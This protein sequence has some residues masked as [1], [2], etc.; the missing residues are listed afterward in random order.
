[1]YEKNKYIFLILL[2]NVSKNYLKNE[3]CF[4]VSTDVLKTA[5]GYSYEQKRKSILTLA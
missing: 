4:L 1:M 3:E 2:H 5:A